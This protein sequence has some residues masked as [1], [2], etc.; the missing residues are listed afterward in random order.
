MENRELRFCEQ[1]LVRKNTKLS[2]LSAKTLLLYMEFLSDDVRDIIIAELKGKRVGLA[3]D[4][5][6]AFGY[7]FVAV[8]AIVAL[9]VTASNVKSKRST[10][11]QWKRKPS[12]RLLP[13]QPADSFY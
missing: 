12:R 4:A 5:W 13:L 11:S 7:H 8:I 6:S 1:A 10:C 3:F 9:P 2:P